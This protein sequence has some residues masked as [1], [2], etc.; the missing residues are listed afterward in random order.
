M[1]LPL[2]IQYTKTAAKYLEKMDKVTRQRVQIK[3][4]EVASDPE[5]PRHSLPLTATTKRKARVGKY[6][7]L[8]LIADPTL[9]V[10]DIDSRGQIY[11][12]L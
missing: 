3:I 10:V 1:N 8:L 4:S 5:N 11:R 6:R 7:I 9:L 12:T 2:S